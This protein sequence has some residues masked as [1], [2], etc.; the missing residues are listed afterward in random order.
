MERPVLGLYLQ[1][2]YIGGVLPKTGITVSQPVPSLIT[3]RC[4]T[5]GS[6]KVCTTMASPVRI[7][8]DRPQVKYS[9]SFLRKV[10]PRA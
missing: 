2:P 5:R 9:K 6:T 3:Y 10:Q 1:A 7:R 8:G 4:T